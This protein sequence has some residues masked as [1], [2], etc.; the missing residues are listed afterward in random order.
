M[1]EEAA[2]RRQQGGGSEEEAARRH[3]ETPRGARRHSG[4]CQEAP[5]GTWKAARRHPD[6]YPSVSAAVPILLLLSSVLK[7][8]KRLRAA[9]QHLRSPR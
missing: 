4:G 2:R 1:I 7:G 3:Q 8:P 9:G 6:L 5:A